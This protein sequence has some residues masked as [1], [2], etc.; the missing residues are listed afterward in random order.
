MF[1][2]FSQDQSVA[3]EDI[4][5][6]IFAGRIEGTCRV[7]LST[8]HSAKGREFDS[9]ILYGMNAGLIPNHWDKQS[10]GALREARRLFYVGVTRPRKELVIV[11]EEGNHS[12][13]LENSTNGASRPMAD[14]QI[15][16]SIRLYATACW[17]LIE[18]P[19][20]L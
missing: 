5:L 14:R 6:N 7:N 15:A 20:R 18:C 9:V 10:P 4:P 12:P 16:E 3:R 17:T 13:W 19:A 8:L 2:N 11:Y 1:G